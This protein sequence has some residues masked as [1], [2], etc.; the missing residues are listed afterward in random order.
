MAASVGWKPEREIEIIAGTPPGGGTDRSAR[1]LLR[2]IEASRLVDVPAK[3]VNIAGEG[4][5]KAWRHIAGRV[6]DPNVIGIN[7]PSHATDVL[8]GALK[9]EDIRNTPL[10]ILY[11]EYLAFI[12]RPGSAFDSGVKFLDRLSA[13][14]ANVTIALSTSLGNPNHIAVAKVMRHA[15][16]SVT[17][18]KIRVFDSARDVVADIIAGNADVGVIT[19]ASTVPELQSEEVCAI[20]VS[21]AERLPGVF[22]S[23]PTWKEQG[24]DCVIGAWRGAGAAAGLTEDQIDYWRSVLSKAVTT[25]EWKEEAERFF[26]T[27]MYTDGEKLS[28]YLKQEYSEMEEILGALG[29]VKK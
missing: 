13:D 15:G 28:A 21:A 9:R 8:M 6:G 19:A 11:N 4:G 25:K 12:A 5:R 1:A 2:A 26:W 23:A 17:A 22:A 10:A 14:A 3:V 20:A 24:I 29:L 27:D 18:P 7:A 16:A